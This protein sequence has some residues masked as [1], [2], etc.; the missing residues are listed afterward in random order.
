MFYWLRKQNADVIAL[1]ETHLG[2]ESDE[3][4][5]KRE[6]GG[7]SHWSVV[8][9][10]S[11]G[12]AILFKQKANLTC[13]NV[14]KDKTGRAISCNIKMG[15]QII[16]VTNVYCPNKEL[17]RKIFIEKE[18]VKN[19]ENGQ[20]IIV[21]DFNC[22]MN[23]R[24]RCHNQG[25][26]VNTQCEHGRRELS[27]LMVTNGLIDVY[28][29]RFPHKKV[30]TYFKP[31][32]PIKSRIDLCLLSEGLYP[33]VTDTGT[34]PATFSDHHA[35]FVNLN[36]CKEERGSG[37]WIMNK[38]VIR[39]KMFQE[40][41]V[42][43]WRDWTKKKNDFSSKLQWWAESKEQI[44]EIAKWCAVQL[45]RNE[46]FRVKNL[47]AQLLEES[48]K[49]QANILEINKLR[50]ELD[51]IYMSKSEGARIRA[52]VKWFEK[53]EKSSAY[54]HQLEKKYANEKL[55]ISIK[56]KDGN[57]LFGIR[58]ILQRQ[59]EFYEELYTGVDVNRDAATQLLQN[60][61]KKLTQEE[62]DKTEADINLDE[63][64]AVV[65]GLKPEKSPG[66][67]G[68]I[69]EF[70]QIYWK[71]IGK[72]FIE[73][74]HDIQEKGILAPGQNMGTVILLHKAGERENLSNWRP[75]TLLNTDYKI[76][77]KVL[78]ERMKVVLERIIHNDQKA[79]LKN[80][81]I[82]ENVRLNDDVIY[83]CEHYE[84][85]GGVLYIDQ[86]KAFDR[87]SWTWLD[88]VLEKYGF[89]QQFRQWVNILY[90]DAKS[91]IFTNRFF[92]EAFRVHR[93]V[94][95][96]S[97]LGPYLY[98]LQCE[99]LAST[100]R[101]D[102]EIEGIKVCDK[103]E[104]CLGEI[105]LAA[106]ADDVQGYV[107]TMQSVIKWFEHMK[108][109]SDASGAV[110][111]V[112]K[113]M[114]TLLGTLK[115]KEN[116]APFM[117][118]TSGPVKV[119]GVNQGINKD[120]VQFWQK[121]IV[122]MKQRLNCWK[123]RNLTLMGK[124]YLLKSIGLSV[125]L[126]A[127]EIQHAPLN[128]IKEVNTVMWS[129]IWNGKPE[130]VKRAVCMRNFAEGGIG[131][132]NIHALI[133]VCRV[134]MLGNI[135][136]EGR[137]TWKLLP[138][139]FLGLHD[140]QNPLRKLLVIGQNRQTYEVPPFYGECVDAWLNLDCNKYPRVQNMRDHLDRNDN[141]DET[142]ITKMSVKLENGSWKAVEMCQR[143]EL[144]TLK[145]G[146][147]KRSKQ[148]V[149][150]TNKYENIEWRRVY[151]PNEKIMCSK[152]VVE[153]HWKCI[154]GAV[155][156]GEKLKKMKLTDG[157]CKLCQ[158]EEETLEHLLLDCDT[159][160]NFWRAVIQMIRT[161]CE[162]FHYHER[163]V[164]M[165]YMDDDVQTNNIV[166]FILL[167]AKWLIWKRRCIIMYDAKWMDEEGLWEWFVNVL[168]SAKQMGTHECLVSKKV[169][170][171]FNCLKL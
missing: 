48:N 20:N 108:T 139:W 121:K 87:V 101:K 155:T 71:E 99:P 142:E 43:F 107:S 148:E 86:S 167:N 77:E 111:N 69:N 110:V 84:K 83:Y 68:I 85:P 90:R 81:Q 102:K 32:S 140:A 70:Y 136:S 127:L 162:D 29:R 67:D 23:D 62:L 59:K 94:R 141:I 42:T 40:T 8:S 46:K 76:I 36:V 57:V 113:S 157:L 93:G 65:K 45:A 75:I 22:T 114:G 5:W 78:A 100:I 11:R 55:W 14:I 2:C 124:A 28:R 79:Y 132:P 47:E 41:F 166:N 123:Q 168:K 117:K 159:T 126:Y 25:N 80:R 6:W 118:W 152:K 33:W 37:R 119:L 64:E 1:Q 61:E 17:E 63:V 165:G 164:F 98:I 53:G 170:T 56:D 144:Y 169:K 4:K 160:H 19:M 66:I 38:K 106:F 156:T 9:K 147:I 27:Q 128:V 154:N 103:N 171:L 18:I 130:R 88:L 95:Q 115:G 82:G 133:D 24:D 149:K 131:V 97:P 91:T 134:K 44:Q 135:L 143:K 150:W 60:V 39:S 51:E 72:D 153:F 92:S 74:I 146:T 105:K 163:H 58:N 151:H 13:E 30:F 112:D 10:N 54:F 15:E 34:I 129:F 137:E 49:L 3:W 96:G 120:E 12:V 16:R 122:K 21:G 89:G 73:V 116:E 158:G 125:L 52:R 26:N 35:I 138:M 31:N 7:Q 145:C 109:Y 161:N 50:A 104:R